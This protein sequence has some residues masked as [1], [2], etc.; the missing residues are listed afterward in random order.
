MGL[1]SIFTGLFNTKE[2]LETSDISRAEKAVTI[3]GIASLGMGSLQGGVF[4]SAFAIALGANNYEIGLIASFAFISQLMQLPGL[5]L[6][7]NVKKR[8]AITFLSAGTSRF[9]WLFIILIPLLFVSRGIT[10]MLQWL[11]ISLLAGALAGPSWNS[12]LRD[13]IPSDKFGKI[14]S[15][16]LM[17]GTALALL[18]TICG[19]YFVDWWSVRFPTSGLYA[20]SILFSVGLLLGIIGITAISRV[21]E[22]P[23]PETDNESLLKE[24]AKPI[25]EFNFRRLLVFTG[26]WTFAV[27][28]AGPFFIVYMLDRIGLSVFMITLLTVTSQVANIVFFRIWGK[29]AD[30]FSNKSVLAITGPIFI[31]VILAWTFTTMPE[32]YFLTIPLLFIIH[33]LSGISTAG[34]TLAST[35]IALKLSPKGEAHI[36]MTVF[37]IVAAI[38]GSISPLAGGV[39]ADFFSARELSLTL[40][41]SAPTVEVSMYALNFKALDFL[42]FL[43]FIV[44]IIS[45]NR[46]SLIKEEGEVEEKEVLAH[47]QNELALPLRTITSVE[48]LRRLVVFP[49]SAVTKI[50]KGKDTG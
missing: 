22:P 1:Y 30:R 45:L 46:L 49:I 48:G 11:L 3:D 32:R 28:L 13:V 23:M 26:L 47:L 42:F 18:L 50:T 20:Y 21:P 9:L 5:I 41:W 10:F 7:K 34:V 31:I 39:V 2:Q 14:F 8:R 15:K 38:A 19:G 6:L 25:K 35:N 43:A 40:N 24:L 16:R 29:A 33:I 37:S 17:W 27:N 36:Y 12:L 4:L 44:G